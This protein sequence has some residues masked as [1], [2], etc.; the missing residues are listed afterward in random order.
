VTVTVGLVLAACA[1]GTAGATQRPTTTPSSGRSTGSPVTTVPGGSTPQA[2]QTTPGPTVSGPGGWGPSE[3]ALAKAR[4]DVARLSIRQLAGQL[5]VVR[6]QGRSS[7]SAARAV[8]RL[9][10]GGV[11]L[12]EENVP[13][14]VVSGLRSGAARVQAAMRADGRDW[15]AII[16][17]DQEGGPVARIGAP[18]TA[19]TG[20]M[21]LGA[22]ADESLAE[23]LGEASGAELRALGFTMVFAPDAD[24][25]MGQDD[26]TIGVRSPGSRPSTVARVATGLVDGYR[27]SGI[28]PVAKHFPGHG[29]VTANS[30]LTLPVQRASL[31]TLRARD[32]APFKALVDNGAPAIMVT[33][34][35]VRALDPRVPSSLSRKVITGQLRESLGF[36]G[37]VVTDAL[38]M[39]AITLHDGSARAAVMAVRAGADVLLMPADPKAAVDGLV[40]AVAKGT[41]SRQRLEASAAKTVALMRDV[42]DHRMPAATTV[43]SHAVLARAVASSSITVVSG[44]CS[45]RLVG[46]SVRVVGGTSTDRARFTA[47]ARKAGLRTGTGAVVRLLPSGSSYGSGDVVVA[48]DTPYGLAHSTAS[49]ARIA[50]Y[51]RTGSVFSSLL[52]VL[53]GEAVA[54]G[55]LPVTVGAY[56]IGTGCPR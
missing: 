39:A 34:I 32:F 17:V 3:A 36:R 13:S 29:S 46:S 24:V 52:K 33:H 8:A 41:L 31:T 27:R 2:R 20:A 9:H 30:H 15:P 51:G 38:D 54:P 10:L 28:V 44:P 16:A 1:G 5:V 6:Y 49:R 40:A 42:A 35:D 4:A 7:T 14:N 18:A 19:F 25:T 21:A 43:G 50:A 12:F 48:L 37:L 55:R 53:T 11:I 56:A 22:A 23:K 26:P 45:G 47:A